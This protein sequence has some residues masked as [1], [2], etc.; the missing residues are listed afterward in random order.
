MNRLQLTPAVK[1]I[2]IACI[3][4][5][6]GTKLL[7]IRGI[8]DLNTLLAMHYPLNPDFKPWQIITHMFMHDSHGLSPHLIFNMIALITIGPTV[9]NILGT[10]KFVK[11]FFFA[12]LGS[13]FLHVAVESIL[14]YNALG[15][16]FPSLSSLQI[17]IL[18]DG[19]YSSQ[20]PFYTQE[21]FNTVTRAYFG[22]LVG[23][24]GAIYGIVVA[25]A[26][27][28]PN[29]QLMFLFIPYPIKAKY[30]V[31]IIIGLDVYLGISNFGWDPVAHFA[32]IGGAIAGWGLAWYWRHY[33]RNRFY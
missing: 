6:I 32:H 22:E 29:T 25:F 27:Y 18:S 3:V 7:L 14:V 26:Y 23:A 16:W 9:E 12:G 30:L 8:F 20:A 5:Y 17:D 13:I 33:G 15:S 11:L 21:S 1:N 10:K 24:S 4:L 19:S 28:F 2:T 31:P